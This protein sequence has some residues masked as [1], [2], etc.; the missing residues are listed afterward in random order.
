MLMG[1]ASNARLARAADDR[2]G[3]SGCFESPGLAGQLEHGRA[4]D[5]P[6][7]RGR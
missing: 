5:R 4:M 3:Y 6:R 2:T 7:N 1:V